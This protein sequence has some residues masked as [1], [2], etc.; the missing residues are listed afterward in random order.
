MLRFPVL[1]GE[2][3]VGFGHDEAIKELSEAYDD[4]TQMLE[5]LAREGNAK[6]HLQKEYEDLRAAIEMDILATCSSRL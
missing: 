1:R 6:G 2:L 3:Q 4:V 5:A